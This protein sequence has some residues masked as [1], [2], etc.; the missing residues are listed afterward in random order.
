MMYEATTL[1]R[2]LTAYFGNLLGLVVDASIFRGQIPESVENG[3]SLR[4]TGTSDATADDNPLYNV[5]I[6]GKF[7]DR[8]DAWKLCT[9][10]ADILPVYGEKTEHFHIVFILPDG[11]LNAPVVIDDKGKKKQFASV[12]MRVSVLTRTA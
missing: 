3:V 10:C 7:N 6:Y 4:V 11:G 1:E 2:D 9:K 12:N 5:Q 8:D